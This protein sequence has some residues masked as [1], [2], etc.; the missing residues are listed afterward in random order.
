MLSSISSSE[1]ATSR[2]QRVTRA[3]WALFITALVLY[4][5][6]EVAA[7][8]GLEHV[9]RIHG[10]ILEEFREASRL[11]HSASPGSKTLLL[12][13]NSLLLE[14]VD[15]P[16]LHSGLRP[17]YEAQRFTVEQTQFLDWY[18]GLEAMFRRGM[19]ADLI[20]LC[21]NPPQ[22]VSD[23]FRGDFSSYV[24]FDAQDIWPVSRDSGADLTRTSG[25]YLAHFSAFYATRSEMRSVF[26]YKIAS[27]IPEM[28]HQA[29]TSMAVI[30]ADRELIP[31]MEPRLRRINDLCRRYGAEFLFLVPPTRQTGDL[32]I[33]S[34]GENVGVR[35]LRP[36]PNMSLSEAY[37]RDS[38]HLNDKGAEL[39]TDAITHALLE[40]K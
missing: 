10:R 15:M 16:Q 5:S 33:A 2:V 11:Q 12:V 29:V 35:V 31:Q 17:R 32:A 18:Y 7:R 3:T 34:A 39:F 22:L 36:I 1:Q 28:W 6:A 23:Q 20:A 40:R 21:L 27:P 8:Y 25:Y 24:L 4:G 37:Y 9:S 14:G 38:F 19:R 13:G 26:M 30:P